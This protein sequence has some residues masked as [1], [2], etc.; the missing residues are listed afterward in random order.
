MDLR[1]TQ[2][3]E[4]ALSV[5]QHSLEAPPSPLSSRAQPRDLRFSGLV[6]EMFLESTW[7][8][9]TTPSPSI[10]TRKF[11]PYRL[12]HLGLTVGCASFLGTATVHG[13][14]ISVNLPQ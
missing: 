7:P 13:G 9:C 1:P 12:L 8:I 14:W 10:Y 4:K 5:Q 3:Y 11:Q 6:L 2:E